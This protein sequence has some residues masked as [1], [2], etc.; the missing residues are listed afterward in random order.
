MSHK[1]IGRIYKHRYQGHRL[2]FENRKTAKA[3]LMC[4]GCYKDMH[5]IIPEVIL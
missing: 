4:G 5:N 1:Y 2:G 3:E